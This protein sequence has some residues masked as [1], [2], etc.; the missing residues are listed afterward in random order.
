MAKKPAAPHSSKTVAASAGLVHA[1]PGHDMPGAT[2]TVSSGMDYAAHE[3][4]YHRFTGLVKWGIIG[5]AV[6][7]IFLFIA[8]HPMVPIAAS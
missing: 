3:A 5:A 6:L 2:A 4:M 1:A 7:L 8:I